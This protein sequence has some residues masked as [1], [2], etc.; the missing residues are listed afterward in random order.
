MSFP[1]PVSL[2]GACAD[3][4]SGI[5]HSEI[6]KRV[7][8]ISAHYRA[9]GNSQ[10]TI[11]SKEDVAAYLLARLPATYAAVSAALS[12]AR[13][14]IPCFTPSSLIDLGAGP[15][16]ASF[17][18]LAQ[19]PE[20]RRLS[21]LDQNPLLLGAARSLLDA[22]GEEGTFEAE[23]ATSALELV[24]DRLEPADLVLISY[25][26]VEMPETEIEAVARQAFA[27]TRNLLIFV[28]P[29]TPEGFRRLLRCR[30]ALLAER[31][32]LLAPCPHSLPCPM[33]P[34]QWCHFVER[35]A[36]SRD[37][38]LVKGAK[39]PFEDEPYGYLAFSRQP[40]EIAPAARIVSQVR[41]AKAQVSCAACAHTGRLIEIVAPHR[42]R[43]AYAKLRRREWGDELLAD[44]MIMPDE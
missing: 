9:G 10:A 18:A 41:V 32:H 20:L 13:R 38:R 2:R 1:L 6:A 19:W 36:R 27:L 30:D 39:V 34:P 44:H 14:L 29:G 25:A 12:A 17:A 23:I 28:E 4:A 11:T 31:A 15:G 8:A 24:A 26:L 16:T 43:D 42:K 7:A 40:A 35:L 33:A 22:V 5:P 21:L 3:Y 37:H